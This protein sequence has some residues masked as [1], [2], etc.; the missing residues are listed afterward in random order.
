[1]ARKN[2]KE[3][4]DKADP[5]EKTPAASNGEPDA[6]ELTRRRDA[7]NGGESLAARAQN[8]EFDGN[9]DDAQGEAQ[10]ALDLPGQVRAK[11]GLKGVRTISVEGKLMGASVK[12]LGGEVTDSDQLIELRVL[13][14]LDHNEEVPV[15]D[16]TGETA[17]TQSVI[18]RQH[19][20]VMRIEIL[21][22]AGS[23]EAATG[24]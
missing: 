17:T 19:F 21:S 12:Q 10:Q 13:A 23:S 15:R 24:S 2:P 14:R 7:R 18:K 4:A 20:R 16:G 8:G 3:P 11:T 22:S 6:D 1:M 9:D 5:P